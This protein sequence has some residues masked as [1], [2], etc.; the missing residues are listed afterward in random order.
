MKTNLARWS[1]WMMAACLTASLAS[2]ALIADDRGLEKGAVKLRSAGP[3]TFGPSGI[4]F[5]ADPI[6]ASIV[7]IA[8]DETNGT[9]DAVKIDVENVDEKLAGM[10]G[11]ERTEV[12]IVDLCVA[13]KTGVAYLSVARGAA[14]DAEAV[15]VKVLADGALE[16]VDLDNALH[17]RAS[18]PNPPDPEAKDRRGDLQRTFSVTDLAF[19]NSQL[20]VAGLS[21]EEF[22]STLRAMPFPF[23]QAG[24]G[25]SVEI[26]HGAHGGFETNS[27]IR[28]LAPIAIGGEPYVVAAYT[29]TPLVKF[30]VSELKDGAKI[31]GTTVAE[32]GNRNRPLDM[33]V[34]ERDGEEFILMANSARGVMKIST[35]DIERAEGIT[36]RVAETAGQAYE[37]IEGLS[38]VVQLDRLNADCALLLI[39]KEDGTQS[40]QTIKLP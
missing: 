2:N 16:L 37:T 5:V 26:Y 40:L 38:G 13:P 4:L 8:T 1:C 20:V 34:Y 18:I 35:M 14:P 7:A 10:L 23:E 19:L 29:C 27:P 24:S 17:A 12:R 32:L 15:L 25:T 39:Q 30:P 9:P 3:L 21:N 28:T 36:E 6:D 22:A 33:V 31:R 11:I